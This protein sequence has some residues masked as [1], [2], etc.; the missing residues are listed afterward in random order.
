MRQRN[1]EFNIDRDKYNT[2]FNEIARQLGG[3]KE[4][5]EFRENNKEHYSKICL[6]ISKSADND[7]VNVRHPNWKVPA[8]YGMSEEIKEQLKNNS[9]NYV[10]AYLS[11]W[12]K[13]KIEFIL[14]KELSNHCGTSQ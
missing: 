11:T 3:Q 2:V 9:S 5:Q 6:E 4:A 10:S 13:D 1:A 14:S 8:F 7:K 12:L